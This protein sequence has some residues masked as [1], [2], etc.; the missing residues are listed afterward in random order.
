[1]SDASTPR[2]LQGIFEFEGQGFDDLAEI[3][4]GLTITVP[5]GSTIQAVYFRGGNSGDDM[6]TVVLMHNGEPV[7]YFPIGAKAGTHVPLRLV[8]DFLEGSTLEL[9]LAAPKAATGSVVIDL[10]LVEF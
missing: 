4:G 8:E 3:G 1:M 7:R 9:R 10:G 6:I 2:F 5:D